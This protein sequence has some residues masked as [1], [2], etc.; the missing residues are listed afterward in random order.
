[1]TTPQ[2]HK[3]ISEAEYWEK[4]YNAPDKTYEWNNGYLEEKAVS[5][6]LTISIYKWFFGLL[7]H[8]LKTNPIAQSVVLEMGFRLP[9]NNE[10]RRPDIGVVLNSNPIPLYPTDRSY[11]GTY[12]ICIE[13]L[14]DSTTKIMERDTVI[15]KGE[16][17]KAG[18]KEYYILDAQR[19]RTQF[20]RLNKTRSAYKAIKPQKGGII[21]SKVLPGF[22]F[23]IEDLFNKPSIEEM[24]DDKVYQHFVMPSYLRE[25]QA[26]QAEKQALQA[27]KQAL[28]AEKLAHQAEKQ[29]R[30]LAEQRAKQLAEQLRVFEMEH[31]R[32]TGIDEI[33]D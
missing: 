1:M 18:V 17:A 21:K 15:K 30:I 31:K 6:V 27:E 7:E 33:R 2:T 29:A 25:K 4:Y 10:V 24:V 8:Y 28:Q 32:H 22:Q 23:R 13:V 11:H 26:L 3:K 9:S 19:E 14:S 5:D 16:Y 12:D 20:F